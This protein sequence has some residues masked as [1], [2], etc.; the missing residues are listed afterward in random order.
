[1]VLLTLTVLIACSD[2]S[3]DGCPEGAVL[4]GGFCT[5]PTGGTDGGGFADP[6][7]K[8][9]TID[10]ACA[11][12]LDGAVT[13]VVRWKLTVDT[14]PIVGGEPFGAIFHG[15]A[16]FDEALLDAGQMRVTGGYKRIN[17]LEFK[18]TVLAREGVTSEAREAVLTPKPIQRT[19]TYDDDGKSGAQAGPFRTC[20]KANDYEDGSNEDCTGSGGAPHPENRCG[21]FRILTTSDDCTPGGSCDNLGKVG[22]GSQCEQFRFCVSGPLEVVLE[23]AAVNGYLAAGSG[24]V[25]FGWDDENT[26]AE[27]DESGGPN[28]GAYILPPAVFEEELGPNGIRALIPGMSPV[29][30]AFECTMAVGTSRLTPT[31][32]SD[33]ISFPIQMR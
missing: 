4:V 25:L 2:L 27:I 15:L 7:P 14:G 21:E 17:L 13:F 24:N 20:S 11:N 8:S 22:A 29:A 5:G 31:P 23:G 12:S 28:D 3:S 9:N 19:C 30:V 33:L 1:M 32:G 16:V 6:L 10:L 26:G 18:A